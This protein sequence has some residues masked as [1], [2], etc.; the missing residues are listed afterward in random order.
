[1]L[2]VTRSAPPFKSCNAKCVF[3]PAIKATAMSPV[4]QTVAQTLAERSHESSGAVH[5]LRFLHSL[6][7]GQ[8]VRWAISKMPPVKIN[9]QIAELSSCLLFVVVGIGV[10]SVC[11][12]S[13]PS[14]RREAR[15]CLITE[16]EGTRER[17]KEGD[18]ET[19]TKRWRG[20]QTGGVR[21]G[22]REGE[23]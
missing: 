7:F 23:R 10:G 20:R 21:Q 2:G 22:E 6:P 9:W 5:R 11:V 18:R 17:G 1:M 12:L 15:R 8:K 3:V 19:E 14:P 4:S 16:G 13:V